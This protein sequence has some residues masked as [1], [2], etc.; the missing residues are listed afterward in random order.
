[1][2]FSLLLGRVMLKCRL[3]YESHGRNESR[4]AYSPYIP[5]IK[6]AF[7]T[8]RILVL[9]IPV[10]VGSLVVYAPAFKVNTCTNN[11][12]IHHAQETL[13]TSIRIIRLTL[14]FSVKHLVA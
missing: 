6:S 10:V 4:H 12:E 14:H 8:T 13:T 3:G 9:V 5:L 1:M 11:Q 7:C 2:V